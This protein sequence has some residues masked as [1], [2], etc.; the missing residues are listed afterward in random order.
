MQS[1]LRDIGT[2]ILS[3]QTTYYRLSNKLLP[4]FLYY[5]FQGYFFQKQLSQLGKQSTRDYVG[6]TTQRKL[7]LPF[8]ATDEQLK[9]ATILSKVDELIQKQIKSLNKLKD[10]RKV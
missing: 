3:P 5:V 10:S 2:M 9:I 1:F 8:I 4:K 7:L 6:I